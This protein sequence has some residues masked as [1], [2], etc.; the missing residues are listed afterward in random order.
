[1]LNSTLMLSLR[2]AAVGSTVI[3]WAAAQPVQAQTDSAMP[4]LTGDVK[5]AAKHLA[6]EP[7]DPLCAQGIAAAAAARANAFAGP[8]APRT[9]ENAVTPDINR[10]TTPVY[11][12]AADGSIW[13]RGRTYK[14]HFAADGFTY[15]PYLGG[16]ARRNF[17]ITFS[18][19]AIEVAGVAME[20]AQPTISRDGDR[21][22]IDRGG[23]VET[24]QLTAD[25]IEQLFVFAEKPAAGEARIHLNVQSELNGAKD[26]IVH[27][28]AN[29][30]G[31]VSYTD[32]VT[33]D[34]AGNRIGA[35]TQMTDQGAIEIIISES[36]MAGAKYPLTVDPVLSTFA[37]QCPRRHGH[38]RRPVRHRL[39]RHQR[40]VDA[41]VGGEL[42]RHRRRHLL[43]VLRSGRPADLRHAR[44]HQR[45][46]R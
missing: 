12:V 27:R 26:G 20:L 30:F 1:M 9:R 2:A 29:E 24:Y 46:R 34:A 31:S 22:T 45:R 25:S 10:F 38:A 32:A 40:P 4:P 18:I 42:Q 35:A 33:V 11:D 21:V 17:P 5:T 39:R 13:V 6:K 14:A 41:G 16:N 44:H 7:L 15:I 36:V 28:F 37:H 23:V 8:A 43:H 3:L 19:D